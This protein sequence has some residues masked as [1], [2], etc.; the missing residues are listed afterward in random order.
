MA[1][2]TITRRFGARPD[3]FYG[4]RPRLW[5]NQGNY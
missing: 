4:H 3:L 5:L 1:V 2:A